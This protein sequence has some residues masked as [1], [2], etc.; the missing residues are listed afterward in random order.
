MVLSTRPHLMVFVNG[1]LPYNASAAQEDWEVSKN[2]RVDCS[3]DGW[4]KGE[5]RPKGGGGEE[6]TTCRP[7]W[8]KR[9]SCRSAP[10]PLRSP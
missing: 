9:P 4:S 8:V 6:G 3:G 7:A 2:K 10:W 1:G 5:D